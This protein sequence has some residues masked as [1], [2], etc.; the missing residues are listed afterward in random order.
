MNGISP[1]HGRVELCVEGV[2]GTV[3]DHSWDTADANVVCKM[4]GF[5]PVGTFVYYIEV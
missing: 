1:E 3:C 2:W 4:N 5:V